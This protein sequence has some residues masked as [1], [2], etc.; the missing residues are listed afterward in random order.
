[1]DCAGADRIK[2]CGGHLAMDVYEH[3]GQPDD[4]PKGAK[5]VGCFADDPQDRA[6]TLKNQSTSKLDYAVRMN[7]R[8]VMSD[9]WLQIHS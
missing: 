6:L 8:F 5:H 3:D 1:M 4:V 2:K 7:G 9:D